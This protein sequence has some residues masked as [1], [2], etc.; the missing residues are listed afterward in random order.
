MYQHGINMDINKKLRWTK[1][2][3]VY[4]SLLT[5]KQ[6]DTLILYLEEDY[7]LVEIAEIEE[8]SKQAI[9]DKINISINKL[10]AY[11]DSLKVL[12]NAEFVQGEIEALQKILNDSSCEPSKK[13]ELAQKKL[14]EF[15]EKME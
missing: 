5:K 10:E 14:S 9:H 1:L 3:D 8:V 13:V 2:F 15:K 4:G 11:E 6:R 7:N 12:Q